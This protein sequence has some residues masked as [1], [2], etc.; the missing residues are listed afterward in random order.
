VTDTLRIPAGVHIF[1]EA[2]AVILGGGRVF[3]DV[4]NPKVVVQVGAP[5]SQGTV[6]IGGIV[7]STRGPGA[8]L[9]LIV[10]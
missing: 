10:T 2:W 8:F 6:E 5:E 7:F 1:G 9:A 4:D 3:D